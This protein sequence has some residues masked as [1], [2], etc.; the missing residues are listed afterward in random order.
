MSQNFSIRKLHWTGISQQCI[1][2]PG[3]MLVGIR[4]TSRCRSSP[5]RMFVTQTVKPPYF[6]RFSL[7]AAVTVNL[8]SR[9]KN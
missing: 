7:K 8:V 3:I 4:P 2:T 9:P 1:R 5:S 6:F